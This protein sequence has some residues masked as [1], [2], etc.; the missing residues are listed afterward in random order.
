MAKSTRD[1]M[2]EMRQAVGLSQRKFA[3]R[4][5]IPVSTIESWESGKREPAPY[6]L[7]L[8][9]HRV[10]YDSGASGAQLLAMMLNFLSDEEGDAD[11]R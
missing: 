6:V 4:Y 5:G 9:A 3:E 1:I 7:A 11:E 8:L 2:R 10:A